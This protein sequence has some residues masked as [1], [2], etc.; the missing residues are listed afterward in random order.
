ME[1]RTKVAFMIDKDLLA[2]ME[3][4]IPREQWDDFIN[5]ALRVALDNY[6]K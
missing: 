6:K 4:L 1:K 5:E 3:S 2:R